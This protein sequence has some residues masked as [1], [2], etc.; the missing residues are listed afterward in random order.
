[1]Q[2]RWSDLQLEFDLAGAVVGHE[3]FEC[4]PER[5]AGMR[6]VAVEGTPFIGYGLFDFKSLSLGFLD[7]SL[8]DYGIQIVGIA[9]DLLVPAISIASV[10]ELIT[11]IVVGKI[12]VHI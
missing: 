8:D 1:M 5:D 7:R 12:A 9:A 10:F 4:V 6:D 2:I 11:E 3:A